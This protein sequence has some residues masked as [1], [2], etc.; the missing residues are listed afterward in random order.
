TGLSDKQ[1]LLARWQAKKELLEICRNDGMPKIFETQPLP[2]SPAF[3]ANDPRKI[4][5]WIRF[6]FSALVDADFLDTE[7]FYD[8]FLRNYDYSSLAELRARLVSYL[9]HKTATSQE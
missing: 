7:R 2:P 3:L 8:G 5:L 4:A 9:D 1:D 6:I